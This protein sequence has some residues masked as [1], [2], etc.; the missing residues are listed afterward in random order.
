[1]AVDTAEKRYSMMN[2]VG[3]PGICTVPMFEPDGAVDDDDRFHLLN[4]YSGITGSAILVLDE[5][6]LTGGF[7]QLPGGL[8]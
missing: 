6:M 4:L 8:I 7:Q 5:G 2:F 1:M 3:G